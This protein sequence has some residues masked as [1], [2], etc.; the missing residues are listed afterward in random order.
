MKLEFPLLGLLAV[1]RMS[2][3]EIKKW[4][5]TEG[6]FLGLDRHASQIYREL[7]KMHVA[8]L[9][10]FD[11]DPRGGGPDAKCYRLTE[12]GM[13]WLR[14][15]TNS[16]YDPPRR[17]QAPEFICR[18]QFTAMLDGQRALD[19]VRQELEF[20]I[21]QVQKNRGRDRTV[22]PVNPMP[23]VNVDRLRFI[24]EELHQQGMAAIDM[25]IE[26]LRALVGKLE[27]AG[28]DEENAW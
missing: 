12:T 9:I 18:L 15:W 23:Q 5:G 3:Y 13:E 6:Q 24:G 16:P 26:W 10:D 28:W 4:L 22:R 7:N 25:W 21:Q 27:A 11:V 2:G 14:R 20:R 19:L 8:G 1:H 17:F